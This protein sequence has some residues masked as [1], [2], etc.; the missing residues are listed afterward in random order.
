[1]GDGAAWRREAEMIV[2]EYPSLIEKKIEAAGQSVTPAY[3]GMPGGGTAT[4]TTENAALRSGL[5]PLEERKLNAVEDAL[6]A[7]RYFEN[8]D[9]RDKA[10]ELLYFRRKRTRIDRVSRIVGF[11]VITV[12]SWNTTFL[13]MVWS[14]YLTH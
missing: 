9:E 12:K 14:R 8:S 2:R 10:I 13:S 5:L 7:Q 4:R 11:S 3:S 1:M 6:A